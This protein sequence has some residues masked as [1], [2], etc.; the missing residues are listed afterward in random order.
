MS[1]AP[2]SNPLT[3]KS[4][5]TWLK[6]VADHDYE[7][8]HNYL[9]LKL[10]D[11]SASDMVARLKKAK[12]TWRR[13]NDILRATGLPALPLTDPGVQRDLLKLLHGQK[14]SPVLVVDQK[15]G[16]DIADGYHRVSLAYNID[17]F[18]M[19]PLRLG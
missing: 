6:D 1:K 9:S 10:D 15:E 8:A 12:V 2:T 17:P 19:V 18:L 3:V 7:A 14:L 11:E 4:P 5:M 16:A 13:A